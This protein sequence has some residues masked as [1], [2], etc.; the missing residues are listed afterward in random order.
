MAAEVG[1]GEDASTRSAAGISV[2]AN[3]QGR[4]VP[5]TR[6]PNRGVML[7]I[8]LGVVSR[9]LRDPRFH[10]R[11]I[12]AALGLSVLKRAAQDSGTQ[13]FERVSGFFEGNRARLEG[14]AKKLEGKAKKEAEKLEGEAKKALTQP[15]AR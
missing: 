7:L 9:L 3:G 8:G 1:S 11:V 4:R 10:A 5:A 2:N 15:K 14:K 12:T 13:N 6:R